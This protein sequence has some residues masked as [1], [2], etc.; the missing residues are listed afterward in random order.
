MGLYLWDSIY[1]TLL[2]GLYLVIQMMIYE[3]DYARYKCVIMKMDIILSYPSE[4]FCP[5]SRLKEMI[6]G[7]RQACCV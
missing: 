4:W 7:P 3:S 5:T 2:M 6:L 1:G